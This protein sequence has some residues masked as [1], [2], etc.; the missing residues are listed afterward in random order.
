MNPII[1][2]P[3]LLRLIARLQREFRKLPLERQQ[4]RRR[5]IQTAFATAQGWR[6]A[7]PF[8]LLE[9]LTGARD[10]KAGGRDMGAAF[11]LLDHLE[12]YACQRRPAALVSHT[13]LPLEQVRGH[14][15]LTLPASLVATVLPCPSWYHPAACVPVLITP[16]PAPAIWVNVRHQPR[17][18]Y[19]WLSNR[20][21]SARIPDN[22]LVTEHERL[23]TQ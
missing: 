3:E 7:A 10:A 4:E 19:T 22:Y 9:L 18:G 8:G 16:R 17:R 14:D 20:P 1:F 13:Y 15:W 5:G 23:A 2:K 6:L 21:R 11:P 12:Y